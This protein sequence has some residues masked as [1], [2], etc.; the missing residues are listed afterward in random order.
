MG[1]T[2]PNKITS[3]KYIIS[4]SIIKLSNWGVEAIKF[5]KNISSK[6][7]KRLEY[8]IERQRFQLEKKFRIAA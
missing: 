6:Y 5:I 1:W 3:R 7:R 2:G 4:K 8:D